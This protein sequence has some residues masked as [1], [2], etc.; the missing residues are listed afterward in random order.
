MAWC[1]KRS[2]KILVNCTSEGQK[3]KLH[4][5]K[6]NW[7]RTTVSGHH[8]LAFQ[9]MVMGIWSKMSDFDPLK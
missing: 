9:P 3:K 2:Y 1:A 7:S 8:V 4:A 6:T 5:Q